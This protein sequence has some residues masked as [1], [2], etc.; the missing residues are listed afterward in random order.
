MPNDSVRPSGRYRLG[1]PNCRQQQ[2]VRVARQGFLRSHVFPV[3][4]LY[5][6]QCA[7][8]GR[9][10]LVPRRSAGHRHTV[11]AP[12]PDDSDSLAGDSLRAG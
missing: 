6:W 2:L 12:E 7:R 5:P 1:C 8:C 3:L 4:G 11:E 9:H 10:F